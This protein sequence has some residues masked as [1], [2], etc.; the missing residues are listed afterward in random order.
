MSSQS[1]LTELIREIVEMIPPDNQRLR[2]YISELESQIHAAQREAD[3]QREVLRQ[4]ED[5]YTKLTSPANRTGVFLR[6]EQDGI[7]LIAVGDT[8]FVV[9]IDPSIEVAE[10]VT[11]A[12]VKVNDSYAIVG[13]MPPHESG[14]IFKINEIL[15]EQ[16][17]RLT[18]DGA[19]Q[20]ARIVLRGN[21]LKELEIKMGDEVRVEPNMK[22][23]IEHFPQAEAREYFYEEVPEIGW[24]QIGGQQEAIELIRKTIEQ[25]LL[26]PEIYEKYDKKP[27]KGILLY[28][29]PGCGKTLIGKATAHNLT[30]EYSKRT[31]KDVK[32]YFMY[33]SGP[34]ILNMWLGETE[35]MVREIFE[36]ARRRAEEGR[37]VFI[38]F[39]EAESVLRTRSSGKW[40]NI[41]NTVV[42]Q[43]CAEL[44]GLVA[45]ENV[46]LMLTSNRPDYIDPAILR[47]ERIDRK[48]KI[49]RPD[50]DAVREILDIYL[51]RGIPL[52]PDAVAAE[53][54]DQEAVR[55]CM[56][57]SLA[58]F[59]WR[60]NQ[61]TEF[62]KVAY[63]YGD[64]QTLYWKDLISGAIIKSIV[65][66]AKDHAIQRVIADPN[67]T[68]GIRL[69]DLKQAATQEFRENEIFPKTDSHEDWLK[70]LDVDEENVAS[71]KAVRQKERDVRDRII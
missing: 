62:V 68:D 43:F 30:K 55:Q 57:D 67:A 50:A 34:K 58:M 4:Y 15:D 28:G 38:F 20:F 39:D 5:A 37:L 71:I 41:S 69:D 14:Q 24:D 35:R 7:A 17:L 46:V 8:E 18:Q 19:A 3:E 61:D 25:P 22:V 13:V 11:G 12:R 27:I 49:N 23:A 40:L 52:D 56:I 31:G 51:K 54:G 53:G 66:R 9:S 44:D 26:Y 60:A 42:P 21:A 47:A 29:P 64:T 36:I 10:L 45:L 48:V 1:S 6:H 16:R 2:N 65:D 33:I 32:E 59:L 70:L 63:R